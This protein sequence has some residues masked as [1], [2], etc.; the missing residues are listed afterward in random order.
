MI[1]L[2]KPNQLKSIILILGLVLTQLC[3]I[4]QPYYFK[5]YQVEHGLSNNT[6]YTSIQDQKGFMWFGT[7][8]GLNRFDGYTF[9]T[10]RFDANDAHSIGNDQIFALHIDRQGRFYVG[11]SK[12]V[13][14]YNMD[15]ENFSLL[16]GTKTLK[17]FG[18][19]HDAR[20]RLWVFSAGGLYQLNKAG[21]EA[22]RYPNVN[23][24]E[25]SSIYAADNGVLWAGANDG[26]I[27]QY[28]PQ[29]DEFRIVK[30]LSIP[31]A[32]EPMSISTMQ[33]LDDGRILVGTTTQG[34]KLFDP[35]SGTVKEIINLTLDKTHIFVRDILRNSAQE[36]WVG[37]ESGVYIY[38]VATSKVTH[39][40]KQ[41]TNRYALADNAVYTL[42]RDNQGG[43][44]LGTYFGG[45]SYYSEQYSIFSK[46]FPEQQANA[47]SGNAVR[48]MQMDKYGKL[49]IGTED[50][51]LNCLD[52][53]TGLFS[54][55]RPNG[56][57][58]SLM[59]SNVHGLLA[60]DDK[61]WVGTFHHGI[62]I[63]DIRTGKVIRHY[64]AGDRGLK[65]DFV[66]TFLKTRAGK[67]IIATTN[68]VFRYLPERDYFEIY[69]ELP[70]HSYSSLI[71]DTN[72][73]I[74]AGSFD[75]GLFKMSASGKLLAHYHNDESDPYSVSHNTITSVFEDSR[76]NIWATTEGGGLVKYNK[77][78]ENFSRITIKEG[79]PSNFL[80][81]MEEDQDHTFWISSSKG[82]INF[83]P[84]TR[85]SITYTKSDGLLTNQFNYGSSINDDHGRMYFGSLKGLISFEPV[86]LKN[87]VYNTPI[88]ITN[89]HVQHNENYENNESY[90]FQKS[91]INTKEVTLEYNQSSFNIDIAALSFFA[92]EMTEYAYKMTGFYDDW[93]HLKSNR[94]IY[95]TKLE[96]GTYTFQVKAL[97]H[98][99]DSWAGNQASLKITILP[100]LWKSN[101][102]YLCYA[103]LAAAA[104]YLVIRYF[105][106][107]LKAK[108]KIRQQIFENE[109]QKEIYQSKIEF[110]T[111]V[112]HEIRTP[113][114]LIKGPM[115][116]LM[117]MASEVPLMEKNLRIL[118]RNTD[119]L[120]SLT[121]QLLDFRKTEVSGYSLNYV[122]AN[123]TDIIREASANFDALAEQR[124]I[125]ISF[126]LQEEPFFAYVDIEAFYK[127]IFSLLDNA[128][129]YGKS[130]V[131]IM[132]QIQPAEQ[133]QF[134]IIVEND[135]PIVPDAMAEKIFEPFYRAKESRDLP[136][137]GIGLSIARALTE[138]H[139][140]TLILERRRSKYNSFIL[141]LPIHQSI[142][143]NLQEKW[144]KHTPSMLVSNHHPIDQPF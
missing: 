65:S 130:E 73:N 33:S 89:F 3:S 18:L 124:N 132:L 13:Y 11:T 6:V 122:R 121:N 22:K 113:L 1:Y 127:I 93:E 131:M 94:K 17:G 47:I 90:P 110:F 59:Y 95:F 111:M 63:M 136:G 53:K 51:G 40:E 41:N 62:D 15:H 68:G 25:Y 128:L 72:G 66:M 61:L 129:K 74:W 8:D 9:K 21:T 32:T 108:H 133:R 91:I 71:E 60:D 88:F 119:R 123:I 76:K 12:G 43:I 137:T 57:K 81:R 23:G 83:N 34:L 126:S 10:Y 144:K 27:R 14:L 96:P 115:E 77:E 143:F 50:A 35:A 24:I 100:P 142:E 37:T 54:N 109:K 45:I 102:A 105:H 97:V 70:I 125:G 29:R 38:N 56:S 99:S 52:L 67:I 42:S 104:T 16:P 28:D 101:W 36:Y 69:E 4:A 112:S 114:T 85:K 92:P 82:L 103:L 138:L 98:G 64:D 141:R 80:F 48:E 26:K 78:K 49:W 135:G 5:H 118:N 7:K 31:N 75:D 84:E 20:D 44:W 55:F 58:T 2:G 39:L 139:Q 19:Q 140:G 46:Y 79:L 30:D 120:L 87:K 107:R 117:K 116:K 106:Q 134:S 86:K